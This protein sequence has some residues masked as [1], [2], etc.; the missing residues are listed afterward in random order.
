MLFRSETLRVVHIMDP[1]GGFHYRQQVMEKYRGLDSLTA[2]KY[3]RLEDECY[4][5]NVPF[6]FFNRYPLS[7]MKYIQ[8]VCAPSCASHGELPWSF[9][10]NKQLRH[11]NLSF[12]PFC[13]KA[14]KGPQSAVDLPSLLTLKGVRA[15]Q[16]WVAELPHFPYIRKLGIFIPKDVA[17]EPLINL[18]SNLNYMGSLH[19]TI[20]GDDKQITFPDCILAFKNHNRLHSFN[21]TGGTWRLKEV[22]DCTL[23][24]PNLVKLKLGWISFKEDPMP[25]LEKL[26]KLRVLTLEG[27]LLTENQMMICSS[28]GF[29]CLQK[30]HLDVLYM[31]EWKIEE[32]AM[33]V[34]NQLK[35]GDLLGDLQVPDLQ[36][37]PNILE[38]TVL[39]S[40]SMK[41]KMLGEYQW[42]IKHIPSVIF[43]DW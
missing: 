21:L 43:K 7:Y 19:L 31:V 36:Y 10:G 20:L 17:W 4:R 24:P 16:D 33:P 25:Q 41:S 37:L 15:R 14:P 27:G 40:D 32:G 26:P 13:E 22:I 2:L 5:I 38:C 8:T 28:G 12:C 30:F 34:L 6:R 29:G 35:L 39:Y 42:K 3:C 9:W 1:Y 18:L 23:F 11:I